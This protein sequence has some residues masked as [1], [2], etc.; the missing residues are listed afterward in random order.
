MS[1]STNVLLEALDQMSLSE[2]E[3]FLDQALALRAQRRAPALSQ[4]ETEL[5]IKIGR[6]LAENHQARLRALVA[7]RQAEALDAQEH[8]ELLQ[9]TDELEQL[10]AER[11]EAMIQLA[12]LR[13]VSLTQLMADLGNPSPDYAYAREHPPAELEE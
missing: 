2:M 1:L 13:G 6:G 5:L 4:S 10:E 8:E 9:L 7:R 3:Q 11:A 12:T